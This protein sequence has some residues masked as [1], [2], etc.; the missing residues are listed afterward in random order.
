MHFLCPVV[1]ERRN[2]QSS[3][4]SRDLTSSGEQDRNFSRAEDFGIVS[5]F[6]YKPVPFCLSRGLPIESS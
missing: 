5:S 1:S 4:S 3:L 2:F 6:F